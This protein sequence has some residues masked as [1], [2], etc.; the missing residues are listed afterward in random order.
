MGPRFL[1]GKCE[2]PSGEKEL[3]FQAGAGR[4]V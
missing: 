2:L 4:E 3:G 1:G